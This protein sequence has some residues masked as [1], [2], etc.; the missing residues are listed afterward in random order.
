MKTNT[1]AEL[2]AKLQTMP[3]NLPVFV[4]PKY[5]GTMEWSDD[6][7]VLVTGVAEMHPK[8]GPKNVTLLV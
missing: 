4:R 1:V 6:V 2:I 5:H 3:Q 7:P 8:D